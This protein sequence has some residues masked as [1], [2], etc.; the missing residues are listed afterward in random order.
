[1]NLCENFFIT[2]STGYIAD[3]FELN[4]RETFKPQAYEVEFDGFGNFKKV[5]AD[6]IQIEMSE[7]HREYI[8]KIIETVKDAFRQQLKE[9]SDGRI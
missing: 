7:H 6:D 1:M 9:Q 2:A 8:C 4:A 3:K 5:Q